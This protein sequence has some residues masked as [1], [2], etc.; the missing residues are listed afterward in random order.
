[1][2][3][4]E[5][6]KACGAEMEKAVKFCPNCGA[7]KKDA[8][9]TRL[10]VVCAIV[11]IIGI[12]TFVFPDDAG[13]KTD[14]SGLGLKSQ[15]AG[16]APEATQPLADYEIKYQNSRVYKNSIG[17]IACYAIVEIE[18]TGNVDLYLDDATFDFEDSSGKL[19]ATYNTLISS[20]PDIIAPGE[21]GY[22]YCNMST[23]R[24]DIDEKTEYI[25]VPKLKVKQSQK[26]IIRYDISDLSISEGNSFSPFDVIGRI[27]NNTGD[28]AGLVWI[29]CVFYRSDGTPIAAS[30]TNITDLAKG[31]TK[32][33][34]ISTIDMLSADFDYSEIADYKVFACKTQ[35]QF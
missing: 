7:K 10:I 20:D 25:F 24:G 14:A 27:T 29:A 31:E 9:Y 21:K 23:L 3:K 4:T 18:N 11:A 26:A 30:G 13:N 33:F 32:T 8:Y 22:F 12:G 17:H 1:M 2:A 35:Y 5:K 16:T 15:S 6:C 34:N 28:D 19:L